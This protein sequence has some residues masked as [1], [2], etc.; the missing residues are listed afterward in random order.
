M[1][2][3]SSEGQIVQNP[4]LRFGRLHVPPAVGYGVYHNIRKKALQNFG[5]IV[6]SAPLVRAIIEN[7]RHENSHILQHRR[8]KVLQL[9]W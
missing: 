6:G 4:A 7:V 5:Q 1:K 9:P 2:S 8:L 3:E